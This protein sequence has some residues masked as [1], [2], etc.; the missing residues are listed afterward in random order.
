MEELVVQMKALLQY[1]KGGNIHDGF[2]QGFDM[3]IFTFQEISQ[4]GCG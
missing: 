4:G 2:N 1:S 3:A